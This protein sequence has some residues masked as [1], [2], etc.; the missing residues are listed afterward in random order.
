MELERRLTANE[1]VQIL[2]SHARHDLGVEKTGR[3]AVTISIVNNKRGE[4]D[5]ALISISKVE[6]EAQDE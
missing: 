6:P 2:A 3:Y 4:F 5:G 1:C